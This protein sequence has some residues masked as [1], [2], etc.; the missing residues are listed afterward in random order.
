MGGAGGAG[1]ADGK[2][3]AGGV[4]DAGGAG[5][6]DEKSVEGCGK[7]SSST[8][9]VEI[10]W[11]ARAWDAEWSVLNGHFSSTGGLPAGEHMLIYSGGGMTPWNDIH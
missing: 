9:P 7:D 5:D 1:G 11:N 3:G 4:E 2:G 8:K 6:A 10:D